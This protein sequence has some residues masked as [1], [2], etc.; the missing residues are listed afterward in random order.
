MQ[1]YKQRCQELLETALPEDAT[2]G[3]ILE[4]AHA[5]KD[6]LGYAFERFEQDARKGEL[7]CIKPF[8][9]RAAEHA[10][11]IAGVLAAF[12]KRNH[13]STD[14]MQGALA[15]T[16]YSLATWK[17]VIDDSAADTRAPA[18]LRLYEWLTERPQWCAGLREML[19][20][21]PSMVRS[22][23]KRDDALELLTEFDLV[24]IVAGTATAMIPT[25]GGES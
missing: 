4:L 21:G 8:A 12:G 10:C 19:R 22:K 17:S 13:V 24:E 2:D 9:L 3:P 23:D 1:S 16:A 14:D 25:A 5:A 11:R 6:M 18:A 7:R 20:D 15:L